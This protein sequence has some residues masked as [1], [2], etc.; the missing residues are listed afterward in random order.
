MKKA[1]YVFLF[2]FA[3]STQASVQRVGSGPGFRKPLHADEKPSATRVDDADKVR[4]RVALHPYLPDA[5][6]DNHDSLKRYVEKGVR[7][8]SS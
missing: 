5:G 3:L 2:I 6:R 1:L 8:G 4:L 7:E